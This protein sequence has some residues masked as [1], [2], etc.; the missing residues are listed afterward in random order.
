MWR[1]D[2]KSKPWTERDTQ[3]NRWKIQTTG[4]NMVHRKDR[5][6]GGWKIQITD[7]IMK[8]RT[9]RWTGD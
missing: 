5:R 3:L 7:A 4:G 9:D 1:K 2:G 6:T 8:H